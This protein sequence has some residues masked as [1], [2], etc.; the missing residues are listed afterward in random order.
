MTLGN[1]GAL[2]LHSYG[3]G[4][5]STDSSGN[6]TARKF[7]TKR[8][9]TGSVSAGSTALVTVTWDVSFADTNYTPWADVLDATTSSLSLSVVHIE[10]IAAGSITLRVLNSGAGSLTGTVLAGAIHD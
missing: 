4:M 10:S 8:V 2:R 6:V 9:T 1:D 5:L 7:Q 3:A